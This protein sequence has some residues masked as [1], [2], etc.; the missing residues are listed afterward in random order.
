M[1]PIEP[2]VSVAAARNAS[3]RDVLSTRMVSSPVVSLV[4]ILIG[5]LITDLQVLYFHSGWNRISDARDVNQGFAGAK[6]IFEVDML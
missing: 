4:P 3:A 1:D 6:R 5:R 2:A